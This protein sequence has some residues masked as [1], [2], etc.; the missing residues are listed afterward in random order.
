MSSY[1]SPDMGQGGAYWISPHKETGALGC[2]PARGSLYGRKIRDSPL[3]SHKGA[4]L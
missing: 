4:S 1:L 2:V 3:L